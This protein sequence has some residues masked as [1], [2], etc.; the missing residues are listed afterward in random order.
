MPA[1]F[2]AERLGHRDLYSLDV[3][4]APDRLEDRVLEA[5]V[6]DLVETHL[7]EVVVDPVQ[8]GLV[9]VLMKVVRERAGRLEVVSERLL[10]D[11]PRALGEAGV[12]ELLY[13]LPEQEGRDLEVEDRCRRALDRVTD[14]LVGRRIREVT[15]HVG[16]ALDEAVEYVLVDV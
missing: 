9:D 4:A 10:H 2:D 11:D 6:Q 12:G 5:E 7:P 15:G 16:E 13:D 8:L 1:I 14:A 3:I